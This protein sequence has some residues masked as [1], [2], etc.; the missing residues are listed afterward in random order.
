[1]SATRS[2]KVSERVAPKATEPGPQKKKKAR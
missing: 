1:M 2:P